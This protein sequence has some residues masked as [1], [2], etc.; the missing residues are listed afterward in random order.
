MRKDMWVPLIFGLAGVAILIS[1]GNWQIRRLDEKRVQLA[2]IDRRIAAAPVGLP[3]APDPVV[4]KYLPVRA[5]GTLTGEQ[6]VV[7]ASLKQI[8]AIHRIISVLDTGE[9]RVLVDRGYRSLL[10]HAGYLPTGTIKLTG[11]LHWP[12]ETDSYTPEPEMKG[13]VWLYFAR[14]VRAMAV[15]LNT[16]PLLIVAREITPEDPQLTPLPVTSALIPNDH[17][18]YAITW[19]LLSL[20]WA[21]MTAYLLWRIRQR[22]V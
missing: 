8:G 21:G 16:E 20:V 5:A 10:A 17:L 11:N 7:L 9:R 6:V 3:A 12:D 4:D 1:L 22:T 15:R 2:E 14:D 19:F 13:V 18:E